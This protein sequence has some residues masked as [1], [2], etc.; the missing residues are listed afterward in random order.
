[1]R[2]HNDRSTQRLLSLK[3]AQMRMA[4][5]DAQA[6]ARHALHHRSESTVL[7]EQARATVDQSVLLPEPGLSRTDLYD[8]LRALAVARAHAMELELSAGELDQQAQRRDAQQQVLQHQAQQHQ[9]KRT[10]LDHW[11]RHHCQA[12]AQL[13]LRRLQQQHLEDMT[14]RTPL[15]R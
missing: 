1:M 11:H 13:R 15:P 9:R 5:A 4:R 8:R 12:Q 7:R 6:Q 3:D 10:K 14:C 2:S